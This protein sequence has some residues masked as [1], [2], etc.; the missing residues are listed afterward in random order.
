MT[1]ALSHIAELVA[2]V[3]GLGMLVLL[4]RTLLAPGEE[5]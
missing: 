2:L 5:A 3:S 1:A 4:F